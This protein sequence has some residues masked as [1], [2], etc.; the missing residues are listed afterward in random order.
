MVLG[1]LFTIPAIGLEQDEL[2]CTLK[3]QVKFHPIDTDGNIGWPVLTWLA[4]GGELFFKS[5]PR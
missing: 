3:M 4:V 2:E 1:G 5:L